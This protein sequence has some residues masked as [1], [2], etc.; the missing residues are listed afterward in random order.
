MNK[1]WK[2][3]KSL[4][5][6]ALM[7]FVATIVIAICGI[8]FLIVTFDKDEFDRALSCSFYCREALYISE[9][10][11]VVRDRATNKPIVGASVTMRE[12]PV[13][14]C[15]VCGNHLLPTTVVT[16]ED[17]IFRY[18]GKSFPDLYVIE[19][20]IQAPNCT[21]LLSYRMVTELDWGG[22]FV[23]ERFILDCQS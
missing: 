4:L 9:M 16:D 10:S 5:I 11:A 18:S 12:S 1:L 21:S 17:G 7:A 14:Q 23:R 20:M 15:Q 22:G 2:I 6:L 3:L 8:V 13:Q 19:I